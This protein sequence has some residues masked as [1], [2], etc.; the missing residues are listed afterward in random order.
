VTARRCSGTTRK[1]TPCKARP[2]GDGDRCL[3]HADEETRGSMR[4]GGPQ[5]GSGRPRVPGSTD[6]QRE[7]VE[8]HAVAVVRPYF[9]ALGLDV[10][11]DGT[12]TPLEHGAIVVGR[13][14]DGGV[15]ACTV[16]DL[17]A[18][19]AAAEALLNRVHGKPRQALEH[20][21]AGGGPIEVARSVDLRK[22]TDEELDQLEEL[23][24]RAS[25]EPDTT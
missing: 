23:L 1:G 22:L 24:T 8:L 25:P 11:G 14:K 9:R 3:A 21:G 17:A 5:P 4:F 10:A 6:L 20:T 13:D 15:H 18:Q 19:I 7:L 2:L 12:V 16:E